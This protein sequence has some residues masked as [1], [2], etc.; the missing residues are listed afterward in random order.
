MTPPDVEARIRDLVRGG[1]TYR[2]AAEETGVSHVT[3]KHIIDAARMLPGSGWTPARDRTLRV[4]AETGAPATRIADRMGLDPRTIRRRIRA[5]GS[6][7]R[8][9]DIASGSPLPRTVRECCCRPES[10]RSRR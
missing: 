1:F 10:T 4:L 5:S 6:G 7:R 3:V 8:S 9:D 2:A